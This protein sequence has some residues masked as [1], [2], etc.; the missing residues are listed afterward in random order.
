MQNINACCTG[1]LPAFIKDVGDEEEL[2]DP[3]DEPL[4]VSDRIWATGLLPKLEYIQASSM[5]LQCL[6]E[7][8]SEPP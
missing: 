1:P 4:E 7:A 3:S 6:A 8:N 5:I 2:L